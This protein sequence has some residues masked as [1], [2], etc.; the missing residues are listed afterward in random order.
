MGIYLALTPTMLTPFIAVTPPR[1]PQ[2]QE[3][4]SCCSKC[5][6]SRAETTFEWLTNATKGVPALE[7][8]YP[9]VGKP[10][11]C[12]AV[13]AP[14]APVTLHSWGRVNDD[15]K[16]RVHTCVQIRIFYFV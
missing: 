4:I 12:N 10:G 15:G 16:P 6:G 1:F 3:F 14:R 11:T 2:E 5:Q 9:Y 7:L 8:T 13:T